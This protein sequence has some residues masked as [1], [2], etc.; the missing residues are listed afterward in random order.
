MNCGT[1][2]TS[3]RDGIRQ[4]DGLTSTAYSIMGHAGTYVRFQSTNSFSCSC[5]SA[6]KPSQEAFKKQVHFLQGSFVYFHD[7]LAQRQHL[8][9]HIYMDDG[10]QMPMEEYYWVLKSRDFER[11]RIGKQ[12]ETNELD[13][14]SFFKHRALSLRLHTSR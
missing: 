1:S 13:P 6:C 14:L 9:I 2:G 7:W 11:K 5:V 3:S 10:R 8:H 12:Q 4:I